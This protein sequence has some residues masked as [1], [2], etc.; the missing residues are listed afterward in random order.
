MRDASSDAVRLHLLDRTSCVVAGLRQYV[1]DR[2]CKVASH[3]QASAT[4]CTIWQAERC[5]GGKLRYGPGK[6]EI[7][8]SFPAAAPITDGVSV[9]EY[10]MEHVGLGF[11]FNHKRDGHAALCK[12]QSH[13]RALLC[14]HMA[15]FQKFDFKFA[16]SLACVQECTY[17]AALHNAPLL[18]HRD[19]FDVKL[20]RLQVH[21]ARRMLR[22]VHPVPRVVMYL[23]LGWPLRLA[24]SLRLE[25][26]LL[27]LRARHDPRYAHARK[28]LDIGIS[29]PGTWS[30]SIVRWLTLVGGHNLSNWTP[31]PDKLDLLHFRRCLCDLRSRV[32]R[33][34]ALRYD[35]SHWRSMPLQQQ[36]LQ[37]HGARCWG[38]QQLSNAGASL[39]VARMWAQLRLQGRLSAEHGTVSCRWCAQR[40]E[41]T[42]AHLFRSCTRVARLHGSWTAAWPNYRI[43]GF[44]ADFEEYILGRSAHS[45]LIAVIDFLCKLRS[46]R[47]RTQSSRLGPMSSTLQMFSPSSPGSPSSSGT[48]P[49]SSSPA[50]SYRSSSSACS[51]RSNI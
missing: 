36:Q 38:L 14:Q 34:L 20:N 9:V 51:S 17:P 25:A 24:T 27:W 18:T 41:E 22:L 28:I 29:L 21:V 12:I 39:K 50:A 2:R 33:P 43:P 23:E 7:V 3:A 37:Q 45:E 8:G 30:D 44:G 32:M 13:A 16:A 26:A 11:A 47:V 40:V 48:C 4:M 19:D 5:H 31:P 1:D 35:L 49:C 15:V 46:A 10:V 6:T 42:C